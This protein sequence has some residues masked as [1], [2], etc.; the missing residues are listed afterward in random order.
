LNQK[1]EE[2]ID[3]GDD[4]IKRHHRFQNFD[5]RNKS[6]RNNSWTIV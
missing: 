3:D 2:Q 5:K 4:F 1:I 6:K